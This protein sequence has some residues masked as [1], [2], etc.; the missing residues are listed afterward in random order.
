MS[1]IKGNE[2]VRNGNYALAIEEYCKIDADHPLYEEAQ[3]NIRYISK[4]KLKKTDF[5][6]IK[7]GTGTPF[8]S[9]VMPVFNVGPY[10]DACI[11]SVRSQEFTDFE[12]IIVDDSSTDNAKN[13]IEMHASLDNRIKHVTLDYNT[14][15]GAGIP[16]NVGLSMAKGEYIGFVDSDDWVTADGFR[17]LVELAKNYESDIIIGDFKT[18]DEISRKVEAA[19]D[20]PDWENIPLDT[21][22]KI[23]DYPQLLKFSPVP[24]RKLYKREFMLSNK[25]NYPEGDFF[26]EDNPLH[27]EVLSKA[28]NIV[29]TDN[30]IS[31]HRMAREG[32][33]MSSASF[34]LSALLSHINNIRIGLK[35][36]DQLI[37]ALIAFIA[38]TRWIAARQKDPAIESL[39]K[40]RLSQE[41]NKCKR[42]LK[43]KNYSSTDTKRLDSFAKVFNDTLLTV[44][45]YAESENESLYRS[46]ASVSDSNNV[47]I[48]IVI[49]E[50][51]ESRL[52][53]LNQN[54]ASQLYFLFN[55]SMGRAVN[56]L[57]PLCSGEFTLF[58]EA[59]EIVNIE[60]I[61]ELIA[62]AKTNKSEIVVNINDGFDCCRNILVNRGFMHYRNIFFG[63]TDYSAFSF[64]WQ[65]VLTTEKMMLVDKNFVDTQA[66][67]IDI[68]SQDFMKEIDNMLNRT[69]KDVNEKKLNLFMKIF[70]DVLLNKELN[71]N[72]LELRGLKVFEDQLIGKMNQMEV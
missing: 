63:P 56:A 28:K 4:F 5:M 1:L 26:F 65:A 40:K 6:E 25:I 18:F 67:K 41:Y 7:R 12:L 15:G 59:G 36:E 14:L 48:L 10:L 69:K 21:Q 53:Q 30:T 52:E 45:I 35:R 29:V 57:Q 3:F 24:W 46:L 20:K 55:K 43:N 64:F 17:K 38:K 51:D 33:T 44:V 19:Y 50:I 13:I 32:Q 8:L 31:F 42:M 34:R 62:E 61:Y 2:F 22:I 49:K 60:N 37:H 47:N 16:S 71:M 11:I 58:I 9:I 39:F 70:S 68:Q 54:N 72:A 66:R 27:W 23:A